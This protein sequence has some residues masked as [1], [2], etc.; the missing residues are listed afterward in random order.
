MDEFLSQI[1]TTVRG[2]WNY[3]RLAMLVAWLVA[4]AG[5]TAVML[6]PARYQASARVYLDTQTILRPLMRGIAV[7]PN[8]EQ[9]VAMLSRTLISRPTVERLIRQADLDL[10]AE[11][12]AD[13]NALIDSVTKAISIRTTKRDNL[14]TLSY[15]DPNPQVAQ[16]VVQA[17]L[18]IFVESSL[19]ASRQ[20]SD[21]ARRFL[22]EQIKGYEAKLTDAESRLKEFKLRNIEMQSQAGLDSIERAAEVGNKLGQARLELREAESARAAAS[23]QLQALRSQVRQS[24]ADTSVP[25]QT[26]EIDARLA[27]QKSNLD[28]LLQRYTEAHPDVSNTRRLIRELEAQKSKEVDA[29]RRQALASP[30]AQGAESNPALLEP[31]RLLSVAE[32]QVA[33]LRARV[34]EY[35]AR[36]I[37]AQEHL[38]VAPQLEAELAQLNRDYQIHQKNYSDLVARRESALMSG[39]LENT[40]SAADFRVIDPP[41]VDP[42]PVAPNKIMLLPVSLLAALGA[43]F[44][45]AFLVSQIRPVF[46]DGT[47]LRQVTEL[48]L[49]GVVELIPNEELQR[50][51]T[52]SLR[53]FL[54]ALFALVFLYASGIF[55]LFYKSGM[56][57]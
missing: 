51:E 7:Q 42:N 33:S 37:Q 34:A 23:R 56:P 15:Q 8:I 22:D 39:E 21:S 6:M 17:L 25:I 57:G 36:A 48:P 9:Q 55:A 50:K 45:V 46:F 18:A 20:D 1:T 43:G 12:K 49:L 3:R 31:I 32:V 24:L 14:Y 4:A 52:R 44:G 53:R 40:S 29:L 26:P 28:G 5:V 19:G 30:A 35:E 16:R 38:K 2:M 27:T 41:R 13:K 47:S 10:G 11:S 54:M